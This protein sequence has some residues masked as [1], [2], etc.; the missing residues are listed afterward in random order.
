MGNAGPFSRADLATR[1]GNAG[2]FSRAGLASEKRKMLAFYP[3]G[4]GCSGGNAGL[5]FPGGFD[6]NREM[7]AFFP[8]RVWPLKKREMLAFFPRRLGH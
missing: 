7:L 4:G 1:R 8:G 5:F 2:I 6:H 3:E